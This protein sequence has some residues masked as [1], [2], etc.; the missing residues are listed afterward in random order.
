MSLALPEAAQLGNVAQ[1]ETA[2]V[3]ANALGIERAK[4]LVLQ[5]AAHR[6]CASSPRVEAHI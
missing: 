6:S 2:K 1:S 3:A 5:A 4:Q